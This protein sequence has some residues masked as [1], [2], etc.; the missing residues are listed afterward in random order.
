M[1]LWLFCPLHFDLFHVIRIIHIHCPH[2]LHSLH[3]IHVFVFVLLFALFIFFISLEK[4]TYM[5]LIPFIHYIDLVWFPWLWVSW[6]SPPLPGFFGSRIS[7]PEQ[8]PCKMPAPSLKA[9]FVA[10]K[11]AAPTVHPKV[12][13][14][15]PE[16]LL[17]F[18]PVKC[19]PLA[20]RPILWP[21]KWQPPGVHPKVTK[22]L[23]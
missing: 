4:Y 7:T 8:G 2:S 13:K 5:V 12:T 17:P 10:Y 3:C 1:Y 18:A 14:M 23:P 19:Q 20:P 11:M 15:L 21:I 6:L 22:M 9:N 16:K